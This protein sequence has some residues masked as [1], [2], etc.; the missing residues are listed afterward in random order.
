MQHRSICCSS[1]TSSRTSS[2]PAQHTCVPDC[3]HQPAFA[4]CFLAPPCCVQVVVSYK[5]ADG[6]PGIAQ[7]SIQLPMC[8]F[9][10]VR[11]PVWHLCSHAQFCCHCWIQCTT[12]EW[13]CLELHAQHICV[14]RTVLVYCGT[15]SND[16]ASTCMT[17]PR[18][19]PCFEG[20][21]LPKCW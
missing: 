8:L 4:N 12:A 5:G 1:P 11:P 7:L 13:A 21:V 6:Q 9:C 17:C 18:R 2:A 16:T 10:Q 19:C 20:D 3:A 14:H 15:R